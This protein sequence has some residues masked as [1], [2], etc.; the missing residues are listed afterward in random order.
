MEFEAEA[1]IRTETPVVADDTPCT[2][3]VSRFFK[4]IME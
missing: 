1:F 2:R 3:N 4:G